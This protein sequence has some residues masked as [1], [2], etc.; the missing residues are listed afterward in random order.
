MLIGAYWHDHNVNV[1]YSG[2]AYLFDGSSGI[3]LRSFLNPT[4]A[5][6]D[7]FGVSVAAVEGGNIL[8]G[9]PQDDS[10]G[11][12]TG[13]VYLFDPSTGAL[14]RTIQKPNP[15]TNDIFGRTV[16][17][18]GPNFLAAGGGA[19]YLLNGATGDFLRS[20]VPPQSC[21][22]F[23]TSVSQVNG[24]VLVGTTCDGVYFFDGSTGSLLRTFVAPSP[25]EYFG[26]SAAATSDYVLVGAPLSD[27]GTRSAGVAYLFD[28]STGALLR[29]LQ[30]PVPTYNGLF[31][32]TVAALGGNFLVTGWAEDDAL[33]YLFDPS[34][35]S[36]LRVF[37]DPNPGRS[38]FGLSLTPEGNNVL[39]GDSR[40]DIS[41]S[42]TGAV[43]LFDGSTGSLLTTFLEPARFPEDLF[44]W[45][46]ANFDGNILTS[47]LL[48][49]SN[50]QDTGAAYLIDGST[51]VLLTR[52][53]DP[54]PDAS[55]RFGWS[56]AGD[57]DK[58][59]VGAPWEGRG[60]V[61]LFR[62]YPGQLGNGVL[63]RSFLP[64][65]SGPGA[66]AKLFGYSVAIVGGNVLVGAPRDDAGGEDAGA[67]YLFDA[68]TGALLRTFQKPTPVAGDRFGYSVASLDGKVVITAPLD[69]S[70]GP[71]AGAAYLFDASNGTL[72]TTFLNPTPALDDG[73][74]WSVAMVAGNVLVGAVDDD[75][76]STDAGAAYLFDANTGVLL[77]TFQKPAPVAGDRLGYSVAAVGSNV[78]VGGLGAADNA[79]EAY[80]FDGSTG[81]LLETYPNPTPAVADWFGFSV[82]SVP[83][84]V[85]VAAPQ[86]DTAAR[87]AGALY[88]FEPQNHAPVLDPIADLAID[89]EKP[90]A[91]TATASD[92]DA[93]QT[94]TFSLS[95]APSEASIDQ[96]TGVFS[97]TPTESQGPD[98]FTMTI[99]VTDN[100]TP[101]LSDS[102][103]FHVTVREVNKAPVLGAV[104]TMS[105]AE[106]TTLSFTAEATDDDIPAQTLTFSCAGCVEIGA[107]FSPSGAFS[108]TPS[109]AQGPGTFVAIL[110]V[111]DGVD[112]GSETITITVL[113]GEE[114]EEPPSPFWRQYWYVILLGAGVAV[115]LPIILRTSLGK[116]QWRSL[117]LC[118]GPKQ[119]PVSNDVRVFQIST[120]A[121]NETT[122]R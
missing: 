63:L 90:L 91:F 13:S 35:G 3:F 105:I 72:L 111:Y 8:I 34:S 19:I 96:S 10:A 48:D 46:V 116:K 69:D 67:A 32:Y 52:F 50:G 45:S 5:W 87:D 7:L 104:S 64:S 33:A 62:A 41:G 106:K 2:A 9:A 16:A 78:L 98:V 79:G 109:E 112:T 1:R 107:S 58:V 23:G 92:A 53:L 108:W 81:D 71:D 95:G 15:A 18:F 84:K 110:S 101:V 42:P 83:G 77:Q 122:S 65:D 120:R 31:G 25:A 121:G 51:G 36:L 60:A 55:D 80:L 82:A 29:T 76:G 54:T 75:T 47:A 94:L 113:E 17:S 37:Q 4:P 74:G 57:S 100:G 61:H 115:A 26:Y 66:A 117:C 102:E 93:G 12:D 24:N 27:T 40:D 59:V 88:L 28:A 118:Q 85:I 56:L 86:D 89:E 39:I 30:Q 99:T 103:T 22:S 11:P 6:G 68:S 70:A 97:W 114:E 14:L 21:S 119:P 38:I 49:D 73:F 20:F 44:G 43:Y